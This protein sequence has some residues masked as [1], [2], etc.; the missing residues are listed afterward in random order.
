[1]DKKKKGL[2][3]AIILIIFLSVVLN[4]I[5][6]NKNYSNMY[7]EGK[8]SYNSILNIRAI[9]EANNKLITKAIDSRNIENLDLLK[10]YENYG[11][12]N[13]NISNLWYEYSNYRENRTVFQRIKKIN[14]NSV[15]INEIN[16]RLEDYLKGILETEMTNQNYTVIVSDKL[17]DNLN[18]MLKISDEIKDYYNN[19]LDDKLRN[20]N[21]EDRLKIIV[22]KHYWIDILEKLNEVDNKYID[23]E[24]SL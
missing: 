4:V 5:L 9:N 22:R 1:M 23:Y 21:E 2:E 24:F 18:M 20:V 16:E 10:L 8:E 14:T 19:F 13:D 6:L 17:L 3:V 7:I 12:M 15:M 11:N